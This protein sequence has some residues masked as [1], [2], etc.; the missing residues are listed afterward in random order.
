MITEKDRYQLEAVFLYLDTDGDGIISVDEIIEG[1][2]L[3]DPSLDISKSK[4]R[5][6]AILN[7]FDDNQNQ[8][9]ELSEFILAGIDRSQY[10]TDDKMRIGFK[11]ID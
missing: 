1:F 4:E 6:E 5:I 7:V 11:M 10:L 2:K 3:V 8:K 9:L